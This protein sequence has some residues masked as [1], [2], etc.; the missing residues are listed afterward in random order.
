MSCG[1]LLTRFSR[2]SEFVA[3]MFESNEVLTG[4]V[5]DALGTTPFLSSCLQC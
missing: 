5:P 4:H 1:Y 2:F 3:V